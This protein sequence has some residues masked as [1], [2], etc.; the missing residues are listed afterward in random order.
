MRRGTRVAQATKY[1]LAPNLRTVKAI[2]LS[3]PAPLTA[4]ADRVIE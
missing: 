4:Q 1:G 3:V 2:G